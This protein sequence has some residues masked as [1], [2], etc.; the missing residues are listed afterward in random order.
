MSICT[1]SVFQT[2]GERFVMV[3]WHRPGGVEAAPKRDESELQTSTSATE[4]GCEEAL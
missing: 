4:R 1:Y 2:L 3:R